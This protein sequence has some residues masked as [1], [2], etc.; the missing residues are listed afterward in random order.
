MNRSR[1]L[2]LI[3]GAT[4][5]G[6]LLGWAAAQGRQRKHRADLFSRRP[7][8]RTAALGYLAGRPGLET[9]RLL[10]DYLRWETQPALR[11]RAGALVHRFEA[12]L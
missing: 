11:R 6:V 10:Q 12:R 4:L 3:G 9:I 5:A 1:N 7:S 2:M 8:R